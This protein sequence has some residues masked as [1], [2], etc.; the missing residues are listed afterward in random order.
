MASHSRERYL[1][2]V[3]GGSGRTAPGGLA[4]EGGDRHSSVFFVVERRRKA[5][6]AAILWRVRWSAGERPAALM[7][8]AVRA[9]GSRPAFRRFRASRLFGSSRSGTRQILIQPFTIDCSRTAA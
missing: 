5:S 2:S 6:A 1:T 3:I 8:R 9:F 7:L 4:R